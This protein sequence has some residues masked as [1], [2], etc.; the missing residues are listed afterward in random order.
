MK[1]A[2]IWLICFCWLLPVLAIAQSDIPRWTFKTELD[3]ISSDWLMTYIAS[4][5]EAGGMPIIT[6]RLKNEQDWLEARM[7]FS[8]F[9]SIPELKVGI[10]GSSENIGNHGY[11]WEP[12]SQFYL[13]WWWNNQRKL[14]QNWQLVEDLGFQFYM[15]PWSN[16]GLVVNQVWL[17]HQNSYIESGPIVIAEYSP[18]REYTSYGAKIQYRV[19]DQIAV[20]AA[21]LWSTHDQG[22][23][24]RFGLTLDF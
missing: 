6:V 20:Q 14:G 22:L 18:N 1:Q 3:H 5:Q 4:S 10:G 9:D 23:D 15:E 12:D 13:C 16:L 21:K 24:W 7:I 2:H 11:N 17:K 19:N 8:T